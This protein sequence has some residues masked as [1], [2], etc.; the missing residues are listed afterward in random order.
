MLVLSFLFCASRYRLRNFPGSIPSNKS[1]NVVQSISRVRTR[2]QSAMNLPASSR[3]AQMQ[4]PE[5]SKYKTR[6]WIARRLTNT[7]SVPSS[8][9]HPSPWDTSAVSPLNDFLMSQGSPYRRT[10]IWPSGKNISPDQVQQYATAQL[11]PDLKTR[12]ARAKR[13]QIDKS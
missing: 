2:D 8:G 4:N 1:F 13:P 11:Q 7:Y 9:S 3:F 5:R 6:I 10:R 12:A